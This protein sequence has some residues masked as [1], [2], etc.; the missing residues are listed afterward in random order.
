MLF[1]LAALSAT[2]VAVPLMDRSVHGPVIPTDFQ[3]PSVLKVGDTYHGFAGLNGDKAGTT[4]N[5]ITATSKDF[6]T[7]TVDNTDA[8]PYP[9]AW[10][11]TVPH[12]WAPDIVQ[13]ANGRFVLYYSATT[14]EDI[15]KHCVGVATS[16]TPKGPFVASDT[17]L[18]CDLSIGGAIDADGF[19]DPAT[20]K[21]YVVYKV[22]GNSLGNGGAC[23]NTIPPIM[24]TPIILQEVNVDDGATPI[25]Q[26]ITL[27]TNN[28]DDGPVIEAPTLAYNAG[29]YTRGGVF[30]RTGDTA[31]NVY[32]PGSPDVEATTNHLVFHGDLNMGWFAGDGSTRDRGMYASA[33]NWNRRGRVAIG[34]LQ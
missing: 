11:A 33:I 28:A 10:V 3:D 26:G 24:S 21:Q 20:G 18:Y 30:L 29:P 13:L 19:R 23:K 2:A 16:D 5:V 6:S 14:A 17:P 12:V 32:A 25:G 7:W 27:L 31:A 8:L 9:G 4:S 22:D 15:S 34:G 1:T